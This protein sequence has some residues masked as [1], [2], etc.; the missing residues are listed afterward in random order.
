MAP[1]D[2]DLS[3]NVWEGIATSPS[4]CGGHSGVACSLRGGGG[5]SGWNGRPLPTE[6]LKSLQLRRVWRISL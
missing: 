2:I 3:V 6:F 1:K 4:C 5:R